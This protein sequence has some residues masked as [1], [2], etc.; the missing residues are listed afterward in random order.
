MPRVIGTLLE[1]EPV[2][3]TNESDGKPYSYT[4]LHVLEGREV[5]AGRVSDNFGPI[6][7]PGSDVD[8]LVACRAYRGKDGARMAYTFLRPAA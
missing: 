7:E 5:I 3:G 2:R 1:I 6:P 4:K 8:I